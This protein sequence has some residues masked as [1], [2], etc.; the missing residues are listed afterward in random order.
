MLPEKRLLFSYLYYHRTVDYLA[1]DDLVNL[2][3]IED[4]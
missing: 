4:V 2:K 1:N 3:D